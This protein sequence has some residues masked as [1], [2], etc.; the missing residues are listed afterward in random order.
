MTKPTRSKEDSIRRR[1]QNL[2]SDAGKKQIEERCRRLPGKCH[3]YDKPDGAFSNRK[4]Q[5]IRQ[6]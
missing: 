3:P 5:L 6:V 1:A 4:T 2:A